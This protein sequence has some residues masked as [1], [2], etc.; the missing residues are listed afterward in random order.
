MDWKKRLRHPAF[1]TG[2]VSAVVLLTQQL[3]YN[4]FPENINDIVSTLLVIGTMLG[5]I[6]DPTT[7]GVTDKPVVIPP[8]EDEVEE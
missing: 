3:G 5:I 4:V 6:V 8:K 2:M 7:S 1:W